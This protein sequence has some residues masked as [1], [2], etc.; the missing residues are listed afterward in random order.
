MYEATIED[1][2]TFTEPWTI[3]LPLYRRMEENAQLMEFKCVEFVEELMFG[4]WRRNPAASLTKDDNNGFSHEDGREP[5]SNWDADV[6]TGQCR[7]GS[8]QAANVPDLTGTYDLATLTPLQRP[9]A[10]GNNKFLSL[11]EAEEIRLADQRLEAADN[12]ASDPNRE[13]PPVGGDGSPGAAGNVGGYNAFWID[14]GDAAVCGEREVPHLDHHEARKRA[15]SRT[16]TCG[17]AGPGRTLSQLPA[18][19]RNCLVGQG[20]RPRPL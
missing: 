12:E 15:H 13:A 20:G 5:A 9:V 2:V 10:F 14:N 4:Q 8:V 18:Q 7:V 19:S 16:D 17:Q 6:D 3:R 1:P 11:E